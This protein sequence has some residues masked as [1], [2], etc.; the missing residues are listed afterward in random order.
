MFI[1]KLARQLVESDPSPPDEC[2]LCGCQGCPPPLADASPKRCSV[3]DLRVGEVV[4]HRY[5]C[6]SCG[7]TMT[8]RP[9]GIERAG[10]SQPLV[11]L[12]GVLY[13]L[14]LSH[15]SIEMVLGLGAT[16][17]TT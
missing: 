8:A 3:V 15:R 11:G 14:G 9:K 13:G 5:R 2:P 7:K 1:I 6:K 4:T 12:T 17:L 10:R 16:A